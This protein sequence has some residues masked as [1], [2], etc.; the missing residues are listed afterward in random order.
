M[1]RLRKV[2]ETEADARKWDAIKELFA[3]VKVVK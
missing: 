1:Q 3:Q 2:G